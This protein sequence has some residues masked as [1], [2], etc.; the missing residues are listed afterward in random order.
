MGVVVGSSS[1]TKTGGLSSNKNSEDSFG[2]NRSS[3]KSSFG[4]S[5]SGFGSSRSSDGAS[6][7]GSQANR[8]PTSVS[9][10]ENIS[11]TADPSTNTLIINANRSD[12]EKIKNLLQNQ[13]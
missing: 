10:G 11:I 13:I 1:G 4:S 6:G 8:S 7:S 12:Y 2:M 9:L 5:G 3:S